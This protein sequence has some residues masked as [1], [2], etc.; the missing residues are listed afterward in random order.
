MHNP[1][2]ANI[3]RRLPKVLLHDHLDGGLRVATLLELLI[4]RGLPSPAPD[5]AALQAWF[6]KNAHAGSLAKYLEGF[7]LTVAAMATPQAMHR[8]AL[9]SAQDAHADGAVLAE[10]RIAPL[11]FEAHGISGEAA[12]EAMLAGLAASP[13]PLLHRSGLIV[14][15]MRHLPPQETLRAAQLALRYQGQGVIGFDL[16]GPEAG[17]PPA[18]HDQ[19]L[20]LVR[21]AGLPITLHAGEADAAVRVLE[22]AR[23]GASRIGHGVR[24]V[25]ALHDPAQAH[26]IEE[27]KALNLHLEVCPTSNVHTGAAADLASHPITAL[28][29]AGISL[30]YHPDNRLMSCINHSGEAA[31]LLEHTPLQVSDLLAMARQAALHSF[32][33]QS[34]REE[35]VAVIEAYQVS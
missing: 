23:Q 11:L 14:C 21:G 6:E 1:D 24:L 9:E 8:V 26:L 30:S 18:E 3:A 2:S 29:Q 33:P 35:A 20:R 16:A 31:A 5:V 15:A 19:A 13:L 10:F 28:W 4:Q 25:D 32:L 17:H 27:A 12:V 22:A 7:A 34:S